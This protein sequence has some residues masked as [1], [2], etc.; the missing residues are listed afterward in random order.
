M[1][2]KGPF[3]LGVIIEPMCFR[4]IF[5][6]YGCTRTE[7]NNNYT[8]SDKKCYSVPNILLSGLTVNPAA[9]IF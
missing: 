9:Q 6:V 4:G 3:T 7:C 1:M 5:C 8:A 2:I